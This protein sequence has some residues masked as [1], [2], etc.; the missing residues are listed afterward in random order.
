[1]VEPNTPETLPLS[2]VKRGLAGI[3]AR[4]YVKYVE[5]MSDFAQPGTM[6]PL[7]RTTGK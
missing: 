2:T 5:G 6:Y 7:N 3:Q 4:A 1:M